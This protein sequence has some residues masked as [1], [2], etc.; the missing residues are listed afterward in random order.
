MSKKLLSCLAIFFIL[1]VFLP[2]LAE[3]ESVPFAGHWVLDKVYE[4]AFSAN[5]YVLDP[6]NAESVYG[7]SENIYRLFPNGDA[8]WLMG[9]ENLKG[10]WELSDNNITTRVGWVDENGEVS[11][12]EMALELDFVYD[13]EQNILHRYWKAIQTD[14]MYQELDFVYRRIPQGAWQMTSVYSNEPEGEP[15]LLDPESSQSLYAESVNVY[16]FDNW[17]V[18]E[19]IPTEEYSQQ[20]VLEKGEDNWLLK[21]D[22][23]FEME[24]FYDAGENLLHRYWKS[25]DAESAWHDLDFVYEPV[26]E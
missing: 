10:K 13:S 19:T 21:F 16:K 26:T 8:E 25:D 6:E 9:D 5:K 22:D 11:E 15:V 20:G 4:N 17:A 18:T 1:V 23:G 12:A 3:G 24:L 7:E 14:S 2:V